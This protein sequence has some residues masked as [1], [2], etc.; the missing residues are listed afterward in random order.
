MC[1]SVVYFLFF[2]FFFERARGNWNVKTKELGRKHMFYNDMEKKKEEE[3][4][5]PAG[6]EMLPGY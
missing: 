5:T 6:M 1:L 4:E 3:E 2:S